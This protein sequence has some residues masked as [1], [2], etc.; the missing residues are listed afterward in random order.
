MRIGEVARLA[1]VSPKAIR[2]YEALGLVEPTR[3]ANGYR[4]YDDETVRLVREIRV[5]NRLGIPV[6]ETRP[7]LECL[8]AGGEHGD[9]CPESLV[10]YHRAIEDLNAQIEVL[11]ARRDGLVRR[12]REAA[13]RRSGVTPPE[14]VQ[15]LTTLPAGLPVPVDDGAADHLVGLRSPTVRL[16]DT[17]GSLIDLAEL[18][19]GRTAIY[20]Y[21]LTG[22][23]DADI[24]A[25]WSEIP[26]ARGCTTQACGFRDHHAELLAAGI[27]RVFGMSS[28]TSEYQREVVSRLHLPFAMLSDPDFLLADELSLPTF[29]FEGVRLYKRLT[30]IIRDGVIEHVFYPIFP[31][32]QHAAELLR[33]LHE[34]A[35]S[36]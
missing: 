9:D 12:L 34:K 3:Q 11:T 27:E 25:G 14:Q 22:R 31:P 6:E 5:L 28:Q 10:E 15:D 32:D 1:E 21:P 33:W 13:Y 36:R 24:P 30:L 16:E 26:G 35:E 4:E 7:F 18:G 8:V 23:P 29:E 20:L 17:D 2:R 19:R